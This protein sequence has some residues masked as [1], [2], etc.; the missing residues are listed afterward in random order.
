MSQQEV[1]ER[2]MSI[3]REEF[4]RVLPKVLGSADHLHVAGDHVQLVLD[5]AEIEI[6]LLPQPEISMAALRLPCLRVRIKLQPSI[7][8]LFMMR[9]D[10]T[11][12]RGGG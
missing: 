4:L 7:S 10:R 6:C 2:L 5:G 11:F 3:S 8:S 9:F 1:Y 12:Q